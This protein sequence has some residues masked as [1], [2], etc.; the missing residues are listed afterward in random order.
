MLTQEI[1]EKNPNK[2][3]LYTDPLVYTI[4][5][6]LTD[7]KSFLNGHNITN[8]KITGT[9]IKAKNNWVNI[10]YIEFGESRFGYNYNT[11]KSN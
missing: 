6:Y 2:H 8:S 11:Y 5:N 3:V 4:D 7:D 10:K 1:T 9:S